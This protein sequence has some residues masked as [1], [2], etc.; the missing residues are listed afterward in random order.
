LVAYGFGPG[1]GARRLSISGRVAGGNRTP[2][3][4]RFRLPQ[5][6][7]RTI[8]VTDTVLLDPPAALGSLTVL[9]T[10]ELLS[11]TIR[12]VFSERSVSDLFAGENELF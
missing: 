7:V 4:H 2:G 11:G 3:S 5:V 12:N 10:A 8:S 9:S 6:G 1:A